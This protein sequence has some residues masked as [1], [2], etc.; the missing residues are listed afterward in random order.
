[1]NFRRD[2]GYFIAYHVQILQFRELQDFRNI[3]NLINIH[4][5]TIQINKI[6][7]NQVHIIQVCARKFNVLNAFFLLFCSCLHNI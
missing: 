3:L 5:K 6:F 4:V 1:M 2:D 7:G